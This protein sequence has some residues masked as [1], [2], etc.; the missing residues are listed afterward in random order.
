MF[1]WAT[2]RGV[3][4]LT[5]RLTLSLIVAGATGLTLVVAA[6]YPEL[7]R[8]IRTKAAWESIRRWWWGSWL[9]MIPFFFWYLVIMVVVVPL[10][11]FTAIVLWQ[12][13]LHLGQVPLLEVADSLRRDIIGE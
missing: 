1:I 10:V 8:W 13:A 7:S 3:H 12:W 6:S 4:D 9:S 11:V 2:I 5:D